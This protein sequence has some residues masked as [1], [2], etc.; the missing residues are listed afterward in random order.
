MEVRTMERGIGDVAQIVGTTPRTLRHYQDEGLIEPSRIGP[1]GYR[2]YDDATLVRIQ[3]IMLLRDWGLDL[4]T[5]R[6]IVIG[7]QDDAAA[8]R[9]HLDRMMRQRGALDR[10]IAAVTA[11]VQRLE[12]G[13]SLMPEEMFD[14]FESLD[15][16]E[17]VTQRWGAEA[18][19]DSERWWSGLSAAEQRDFMTEGAEVSAEWQRACRAGLDPGSQE[20]LALARRAYERSPNTSWVL[21]TYFDLLTR[22]GKWA[23]ALKLVNDLAREKLVSGPE[24]T[25]RRALMKHMLAVEAVDEKR[26]AEALAQARK[27]TGLAPTFAPA[28][29]TA[30][31]AAN[32]QGKLR[33][34]R[35][36]LEDCW[37]LEPH[38]E[39][40][41]AYAA[42]VPDETAAE[43]LRRLG[44]LESLVPNHLT[45]Q[46]LMAELAMNARQWDTAKRHLDKA[47][48]LEPTAGAYRLYAEYERAS[49]GG[50]AKA[51]DWLAKAADAPADKVWVCEDTGEVLAEWQLFGPSGRFDSVHWD[52][53]PKVAP[54]IRDHR[55]PV[56]LVH[57]Q[58][59]VGEPA[60]PVTEVDDV[61]KEKDKGP[62]TSKT[63]PTDQGLKA[64][65]PIEATVKAAGSVG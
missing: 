29:V 53:P 62:G 26:Y 43:R 6:Q 56:V 9:E 49:G 37:R 59:A 54:M 42:L 19:Q 31:Q 14:G 11:T 50:D 40:A 30:A 13:E 15:H 20:A 52:S 65:P 2:Y 25:R 1:N 22:S 48:G 38:P 61:K 24:A 10:R 16:R 18:W 44:R 57:D 23:D 45:T 34:A 8:L 51:R 46:L 55:P 64:P 17:E 12:R 63:G 21:T 32:G 35:R 27:A 39:L 4:A 41:S 7:E 47:L 28:A 3:R 58:R 36:L 60:E 33:L 5:I